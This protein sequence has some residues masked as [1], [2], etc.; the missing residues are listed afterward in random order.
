MG[1]MKELAME[2][3]SYKEGDL[4]RHRLY[5]HEMAEI[6]AMLGHSNKVELMDGRIDYWLPENCIL[7]C[8]MADMET[9]ALLN[10]EEAK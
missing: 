4:V 1:K 3:D 9:Y 8:K 5:D 10:I 2:I 6:V 7:V